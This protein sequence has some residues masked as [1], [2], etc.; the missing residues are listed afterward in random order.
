[1]VQGVVRRLSG[2]LA[3]VA[4]VDGEVV[5]DFELV[6]GDAVDIMVAVTNDAGTGAVDLTG[7]VLRFKIKRTADDADADAL[8]SKDSYGSAASAGVEVTSASGGLATV[9]LYPHDTVDLEAGTCLWELEVTR[10]GATVSVAG[11][12]T[13]TAG[14]GTVTVVGGAI[15]LFKFGMLIVPAGTAGSND[16]PCVITSVDEDAVTF[17]TDYEGWSAQSGITF[18]LKRGT[19]ATPDGLSGRIQLLADVV[20]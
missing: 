5:V 10:P 14:D 8:V 4:T 6:R 12:L 19:R 1:M 20:R 3:G 16:V 11:T 7:A 13:A 18:A 2:P 9:H 15:A 17:V